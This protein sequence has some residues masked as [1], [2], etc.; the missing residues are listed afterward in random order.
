[1][2]VDQN[3]DLVLSCFDAINK[4][5]AAGLAAVFSSKWAAEING[6][7]PRVNAMWAGHHIEVADMVVEG[8]K[9]WCRL[10][11]RGTHSGDWHGIPATG[12]H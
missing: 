10:R 6:R 5:D 2:S 4:Q 3:K 1:M 9:M 11:I 12:K 7:F 8:D